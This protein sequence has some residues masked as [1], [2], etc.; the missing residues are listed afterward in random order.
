MS[1]MPHRWAP[2]DGMIRWPP[3]QP[4]ETA[5]HGSKRARQRRFLSRILSLEVKQ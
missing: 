4:V 1:T 2:R 5:A 3:E